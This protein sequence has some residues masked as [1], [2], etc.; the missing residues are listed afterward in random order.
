VPEE[1][2]LQNNV[3]LQAH[4]DDTRSGWILSGGVVDD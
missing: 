2:E 3:N 4:P 1:R